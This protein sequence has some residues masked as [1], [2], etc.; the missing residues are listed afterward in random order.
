M[1]QGVLTISLDVEL[2]WGVHDRK[3][4]EEY[5]E[6][7]AGVREVIRRMLDLFNAYK[8][9][10]SWAMVGFLFLEDAQELYRSF[11]SL[12]PSYADASLSPYVYA[13]RNR[14][15]L[16]EY[17]AYHFAPDIVDMIKGY[18]GQEIATHTYSHY[19]CLEAG[20]TAEQF[21]ADLKMA[22]QVARNKGIEIQS[23]VFPR[24]QVSEPYLAVCR[25]EG[26]TCYRGTEE[27][28]IYRASDTKAMFFPVKRAIRLVD[29][30]LNLSGFHTYALKRGQ[31]PYNFPASRYLR[32]YAKQ[33]VFLDPLRLLRIN[34][35]LDD[36]AL[37]HRIFHLWAH[38]HE[39]GN[40]IVQNLEFIERILSHYEKLCH[41]Y[42]MR[43][44]HMGE[45]AGL[46]EQD[47]K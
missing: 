18:E 2:F 3:Q 36:A 42:S 43:S 33:R 24:N 15:Q 17:A 20:Q 22:R 5:R 16:Q 46:L 32:P 41:N 47:D 27:G 11:P 37:H 10:A 35:A 12:L 26:I 31:V 4:L 1:E 39:L 23:I 44:L 38:P 40:S 45:L 21:R 8:I 28:W 34:R 14:E 9:H 19:F 6:N 13:E 29:S 25:D 30:Y 7:L